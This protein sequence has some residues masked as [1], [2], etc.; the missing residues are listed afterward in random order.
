[1]AHIHAVLKKDA[2]FDTAKSDDDLRHYDNL[3]LL[4]HAHHKRVDAREDLYTAGAL[5]AMKTEHE[6]LYEKG[7]FAIDDSVLAQA[8]LQIVQEDWEP[9]LDSAV[10]LIYSTLEDGFISQAK[11]NHVSRNVASISDAQ[12]FVVYT[13]LFQSLKPADQIDL[14]REQ[15]VWINQRISYSESCIESHGGSLA[16]LE[17]N[18][19]FV[20]F[21]KKRINELT[22]RLKPANT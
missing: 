15:E 18:E 22:G 3:I 21:T 1:M 9:Y 13:K 8:T 19:A 12:L 14:Y 11:M 6:A 7:Q 16:P 10:D 20:E 5:R 17:Y 2:R 4:C